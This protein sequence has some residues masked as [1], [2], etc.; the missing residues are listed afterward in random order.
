M[1]GT[2]IAKGREE[3]FGEDRNVLYLERGRV[4]VGAYVALK[5]STWTLKMS[6]FY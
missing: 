2:V 6:V 5:S 3:T 1:W 4:H